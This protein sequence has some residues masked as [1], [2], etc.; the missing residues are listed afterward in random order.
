MVILDAIAWREIDSFVPDES[1]SQAAFLGDSEVLLVSR[2]KI[3]V[4]HIDNHSTDHVASPTCRWARSLQAST[5]GKRCT[6]FSS[7]EWNPIVVMDCT[8]WQSL[9]NIEGVGVFNS[10]TIT[11]NG[12]FRRV[13]KSKSEGLPLVHMALS[14]NGKYLA[15]VSN[16]CEDTVNAGIVGNCETTVKVWNLDEGGRLICAIQLK[17]RKGGGVAFRRDSSGIFFWASGMEDMSKVNSK[18]NMTL[19]KI[20]E[21]SVESTIEMSSAI[22]ESVVEL[23]ADSDGQ[24]NIVGIPNKGALL[25]WRL[26]K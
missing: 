11:K 2:N 15:C 1:L 26:V 8:T 3:Q 16:N 9:P 22:F 17:E 25:Q 12:V 10:V 24:V 13:T 19:V 6:F 23:K 18:C 4:R 5:D 21:C 14:P 20:P 7:I